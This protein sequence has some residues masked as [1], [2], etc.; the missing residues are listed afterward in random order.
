MKI[1]NMNGNVGLQVRITTNLL[2]VMHKLHNVEQRLHS[3][4]L[5]AMYSTLAIVQFQLNH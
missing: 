1:E 4:I 3:A 2:V 5:K